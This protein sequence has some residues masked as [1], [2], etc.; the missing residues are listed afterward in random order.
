MKTFKETLLSIIP[1]TLNPSVYKPGEVLVL[2]R[3]GYFI[4]QQRKS[5]FDVKLIFTKLSCIVL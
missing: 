4:F 1:T 5:Y 3:Q 2:N